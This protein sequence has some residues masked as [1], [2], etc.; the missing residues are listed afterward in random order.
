MKRTLL[1]LIIIFITQQGFGQG[2]VAVR[3]FGTCSANLSHNT[4]GKGYIQAGINYRY[5]KSFRHFRGTHEEPDRVTSGTEVIN[6]SNNWEYFVSYWLSGK[7][8]LAIGITTQ[9]NARPSLYEHG[10]TERHQ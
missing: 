6:H 9:I 10:R 7:T 4:F 8:N 1:V 5:F 3:H 2:C